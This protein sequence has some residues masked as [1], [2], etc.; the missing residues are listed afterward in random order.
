[1]GD[2]TLFFSAAEVG[3]SFFFLLSG[4][5]L[6]YNYA[7]VFRGGI[8]VAG[9]KRFVWDRLTKIYPV[10]FLTLLLVL[11][12]A[13]FSP[14]LP[15]DWR[16]VLVVTNK[17]VIVSPEGLQVKFDQSGTNWVLQSPT[18][19]P[20]QLVNSGTDV[21][22]GKGQYDPGS[23]AGKRTLAHELTHV[24]QQSEGPVEGSGSREKAR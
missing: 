3:V 7:D 15:L 2:R 6:T 16:A 20:F 13:T 21:V 17:A 24:V 8:S 10:H 9:Y 5:I 23:S 19:Y 18:N 14:H 22:F 1:M 11:P 4:F 12:I